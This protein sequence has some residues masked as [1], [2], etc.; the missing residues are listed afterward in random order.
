MSHD[1][2]PSGSPMKFVKTDRAASIRL[3]GRVTA[4]LQGFII[5]FL[6]ALITLYATTTPVR[7]PSETS[8]REDAFWHANQFDRAVRKLH[9]DVAIA[10]VSGVVDDPALREITLAFDIVYSQTSVIRNST[11]GAEYSD[12]ML[13]AVVDR[14]AL[15]V[16]QNTDVYDRIAKGE[17]PSSV[18]LIGLRDEVNVLLDISNELV[19]MVVTKVQAAR[20]DGRE[21][22]A[23][24]QSKAEFIISVLVVS[25]TI[26]VVLLRWQLRSMRSAAAEME[27]I[28]DQLK[29]ANVKLSDKAE[30]LRSEVETALAEV[31]VR[32]IEIVDRLSLAASYKDQELGSHT[33]RVGAYSEAIA[34]QM[35]L[36]EQ[37]CAD[38]RLASPMHDI[39]KVAIPDTVLLKAGPLTDEEFG[40]MQTHTLVGQSILAESRSPLLRLAAEIAGGHHEYWNGQ[41][42]PARK[43]G[44][45]IPLS[46]RIVAVADTFDALTTA[47]PYKAAWPRTRAIEYI[48]ERAGDQFDPKCV[49]AFGKA[50]KEIASIM[51]LELS[52]A[53]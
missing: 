39:G 40:I 27:V 3:V 18:Q 12:E 24:A 44:E 47:R 45:T 31:R 1:V 30:W 25:I 41:G 2:P 9:E 29:A 15:W 36:P 13:R 37:Y 14:A 28:S 20:V 49:E 33:K 10:T 6:L 4:V 50:I 51:D 53:V 17:A 11:F 26:L 21:Y 22:I 38:I 35:G 16:R 42:Y 34:R 23:K 48:L 32:D 43:S 8:I 5:L 19:S 7:S 46:A 52:V